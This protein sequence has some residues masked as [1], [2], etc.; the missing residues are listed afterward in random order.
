[1]RRNQSKQFSGNSPGTQGWP[2]KTSYGK[3]MII[4]NKYEGAQGL[5]TILISIPSLP[6]Y[7]SA[8]F[9][10]RDCFEFCLHPLWIWPRVFASQPFCQHPQ[11]MCWLLHWPHC[12]VLTT[13]IGVGCLNLHHFRTCHKA[14][15]PRKENFPS[16]EFCF[17]KRKVQAPRKMLG[18]K[19][20]MRK[21]MVAKVAFQLLCFRV[22]ETLCLMW[23]F[24]KKT[25]A[26]IILKF[27]EILFVRVE[28]FQ[29]QRLYFKKETNF[30][31]FNILFKGNL[32]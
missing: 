20:L 8:S 1:M 10:T 18:S 27:E 3:G 24:S 26:G 28:S 15:F 7:L 22:S 32:W 29:L 11:N 6:K 31:R 21:I 4:S 23:N 12:L 5:W 9:K 17:N 30:N 19:H 2:N 16:W 14:E 25:F 13:L